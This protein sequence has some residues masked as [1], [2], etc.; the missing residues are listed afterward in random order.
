M[1]TLSILWQEL[2]NLTQKQNYFKGKEKVFGNER[3]EV[4]HVMNLSF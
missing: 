1:K 3:G 4:M 2:W